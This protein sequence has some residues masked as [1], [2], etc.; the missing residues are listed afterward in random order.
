MFVHPLNASL[1]K[2]RLGD[3]EVYRFFNDLFDIFLFDKFFD[4][5][6]VIVRIKKNYSYQEVIL[7]YYFC[8]LVKWY[9][10]FLIENNID[11]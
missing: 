9:I 7:Y 2:G 4:D 11:L 3:C 8:S 1:C 5:E 6:N 10:I